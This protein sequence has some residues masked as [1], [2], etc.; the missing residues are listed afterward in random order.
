MRLETRR[1]VLE[2][3][4]ALND[5]NLPRFAGSASSGASEADDPD[6]RQ[7]RI[8]LSFDVNDRGRVTGLKVV[9]ASPI[10]FESMRRTV[11]RDVRSRVYRL[12]FEDAE[13][14]E[15]P[16]QAVSHTFFYRQE[17]LEELREE[18]GATSEQVQELAQQSDSG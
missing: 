12:R 5:E 17:E 4:T 10:E 16:N 3:L 15:S 11:Q 1:K 6:L 14:V 18:S 8:L 2:V 13:P 7:G 9:E